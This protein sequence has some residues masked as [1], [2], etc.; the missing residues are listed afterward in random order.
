MQSPGT[1]LPVSPG[2]ETKRV[3]QRTAIHGTDVPNIPPFRAGAE[4]YKDNPGLGNRSI[5][6]PIAQ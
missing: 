6:Y 1:Y 5:V 2:I 4:C 3:G